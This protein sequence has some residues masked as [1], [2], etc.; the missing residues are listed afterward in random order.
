MHSFATNP[1]KSHTHTSLTQ[2]LDTELHARQRAQTDDPRVGEESAQIGVA[3]L[4]R[5]DLMKAERSAKR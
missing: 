5:V 2:Y 3:H 4:H 1:N